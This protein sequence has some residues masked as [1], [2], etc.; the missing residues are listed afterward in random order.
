MTNIN[1]RLNKIEDKIKE[2]KFI[3]GRGLG[4]E[5]G[6]YIF[7]YDPKYELV[8]RNHVESLLRIF[9]NE[10]HNRRIVEFDLYKMLIEI[11]KEKN[12]YDKIF[13]MEKSQGSE[14]LFTAMIAFAKP[15]IF[16][17]NILNKIGDANVVLITGVGKVYPFVR[18]HTILNNLQ[19][20]LDTIPV[21]MFYPGEYNGL[22][23]NLFDKFIDENYYR[24]FQLVDNK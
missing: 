22:S 20:K 6:F 15:E 3:E 1:K 11:A 17:E 14:S 9:S 19:E 13:D 2:D 7:D 18:S 23:L 16:L 21:I 8:V 5:I 12:I 24:A 10:R 4:N